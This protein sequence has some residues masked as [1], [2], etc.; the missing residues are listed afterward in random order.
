MFIDNYTILPYHEIGL[1]SEG[2]VMIEQTGIANTIDTVEQ[3]AQYDACAKKLLSN[4]MILAWILKGC[5]P[6]FERFSIIKIATECIECEPQVS[7]ISVDQD[8][9]DKSELQY[10]EEMSD[11][12]IDGMNT[13]DNSKKEGKIF[14][15]IKFSAIVPLS[16]NPVQLFINVEAQK[17]C[18]T[19]YPLIKRGVYYGSRMIS[20]QKNTVFTNSHYEKI[21]KVY[22]IWIQ[23]NVDNHKNTITQYKMTEDQI[24]GD[25]KEKVS[26]YDLLTVLM[27]RLGLPEEA[28]DNSLLKLL[29]IL[30][31]SDIKSSNKKEI[32][33]NEFNIPMTK[34]MQEEADVMCNLGQGIREKAVIETTAT[35]VMNIMNNEHVSFDE[36]YDSTYLPDDSKE[37]VKT[38]IKEQN[39]KKKQQIC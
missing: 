22:S 25:Y 20:A 18:N 17:D 36:A 11:K 34:Q 13:E 1:L 30:L 4:K 31:S 33:E 6:E 15:D 29:D 12:R 39:E 3:E 2:L 35:I 21:C 5:V 38:F 24:V 32:L 8:E 26:N 28:K 37:E 9:L 7:K 23:F 10:V 19:P 27:L 16:K 14:Y